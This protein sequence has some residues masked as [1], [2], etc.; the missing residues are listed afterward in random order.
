MIAFAQVLVSIYL[1]DF[2]WWQN[3][4]DVFRLFLLILASGFSAA[5]GYVINDYYDV[6]IDILNKPKRV[7]VG[8]YISR[9]KAMF[10]HLGFI[11]LSLI[12][13]YFLGKKIFF[14]VGF[15]S[16]WL[17]FYSNSL[18][19]LPL[20]GNISIS[21]LTSISLYM[22]AVLFPPP[23]EALLLICL[24]AFW[25]SLI[26]EIAKDMEDTK[27]DARHGCKTIPILWG[28]R[29]TKNLIYCIGGLFF[30]TFIV[31]TY[32]MPNLWII[33]AMLLSIPLGYLFYELQKADTAT[34]FGRISSI[35]KWIMLGGM[36][37]I[38]LIR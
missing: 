4:N 2:A 37:T 6:K 38:F 24:F 18:K 11:G 27:G 16:S 21:I 35:C 28:I 36:A 8:R 10:L 1:L 5:G 32:W 20:I 33:S 25:I 29:K 22:P 34:A 17:W 19:R 23:N 26:R 7:V 3:E 13:S 12:V 30:S 9:R 15:C 31:A 14:I